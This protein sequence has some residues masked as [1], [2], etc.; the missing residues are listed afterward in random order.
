MGADQIDCFNNRRL[1]EPI[2]KIPLAE[3]EA[4]YYAQ[5]ATMPIAAEGSTQMASGKP[6]AV[7]IGLREWADFDQTWRYLIFYLV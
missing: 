1:L 4:H 2:G 5:L 6:V 3:T 7:H